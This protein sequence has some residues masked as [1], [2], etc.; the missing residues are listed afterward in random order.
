MPAAP[1]VL[2]VAAAIIHRHQ[3][4]AGQRAY[5][6]ELAGRWE[7]PGGKVEPGESP[8]A[9]LVREIDEELGLPVQVHEQLG[10][11]VLIG[12]ITRRPARLRLYRCS[13]S[14]PDRQPTDKHYNAL[15]WMGSA[16]LAAL[17]W[18]VTNR[19]LLPRVSA[20]IDACE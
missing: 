11:D 9:A 15:Q 13:L 7:F 1:A 3:V 4:L 19:Q 18:L 5:P 12:P 10:E 14:E 6:P 2:V 17:P 8:Q 20:A 16:S